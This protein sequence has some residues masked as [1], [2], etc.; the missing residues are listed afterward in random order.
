MSGG[1]G[2]QGLW[3][4]LCAPTKWERELTASRWLRAAGSAVTPQPFRS[5]WAEQTPA[6]RESAQGEGSRGWQL[7]AF[8]YN[9]HE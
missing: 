7:E 4:P 8:A 5:V 9:T 1:H 3:V 6:A 2:G